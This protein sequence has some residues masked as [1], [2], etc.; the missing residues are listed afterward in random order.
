MARC[1]VDLLLAWIDEF[2]QTGR[3]IRFSRSRDTLLLV[4]HRQN[5]RSKLFDLELLGHRRARLGVDELIGDLAVGTSLVFAQQVLDIILPG[6]PD[7]VEGGHL[8]RLRR[9]PA[10]WRV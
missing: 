1:E 9:D 6:N 8:D 7:L 5:R 2:E 4:T 10:I 3:E